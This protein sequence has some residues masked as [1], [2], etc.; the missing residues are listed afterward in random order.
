MIDGNYNKPYGSAIDR[1]KGDA[2]AA[3]KL[4]D[5]NVF[6]FHWDMYQYNLFV[7]R[8]KARQPK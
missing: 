1:C 2:I 7:E 8:E 4:M 3:K 6:E 5:V